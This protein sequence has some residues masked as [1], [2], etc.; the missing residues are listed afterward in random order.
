LPFLAQR[1]FGA[2]VVAVDAAKLHCRQPFR[3]IGSDRAD[4]D[5]VH[6]DA[7]AELDHRQVSVR[8]Q[9]SFDVS[10]AGRG[11]AQRIR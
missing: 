10:V 8:V 3:E 4:V 2:A 5:P 1:G 7:S 9:R 11:A 6:D